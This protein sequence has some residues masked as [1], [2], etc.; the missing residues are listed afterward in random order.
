MAVLKYKDPQG[1]WQTLDTGS[2]SVSSV[3]ITELPY[4]S[5]PTA[6]ITAGRSM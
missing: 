1:N 2:G 5:E 6:R 3:E 4:G